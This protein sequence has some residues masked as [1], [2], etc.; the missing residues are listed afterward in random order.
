M[1]ISGH[2]TVDCS[3][4]S[5]LRLAVGCIR[6]FL[7]A[8]SSVAFGLAEALFLVFLFCFPL[9][10]SFLGFFLF[11]SWFELSTFHAFL[12]SLASSCSPYLSQ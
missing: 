5:C 10:L 2:L 1:Y 9:F 4:P 6:V 8:L 11:P 3:L 12:L 7:C